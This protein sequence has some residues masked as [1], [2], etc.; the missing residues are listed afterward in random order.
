MSGALL[1]MLLMVRLAK[2]QPLLNDC[3]SFCGASIIPVQDRMR[4]SNGSSGALADMAA[5]AVK[6]AGAQA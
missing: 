6:E 4:L 2:D 5:P 3:I 1:F